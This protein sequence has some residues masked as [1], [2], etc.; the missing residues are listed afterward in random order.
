MD[1]I[2]SLKDTK[3]TNNVVR[4]CRVERAKKKQERTRLDATKPTKPVL[5]KKPNARCARTPRESH[6]LPDNFNKVASF[7]DEQ[8]EQTKRQETPPPGDEWVTNHLVEL[9]AAG[10]NSDDL[11]RESLP[12]GIVHMKVFNKPDLTI[13]IEL[14]LLTFSWKNPGGGIVMQTCRP[15]GVLNLS[16]NA[17]RN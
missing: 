4:R 17:L 13:K 2:A 6:S 7:F 3:N 12:R 8:S 15:E 5:W 9:Q 1:W 11:F 14:D 16:A 10:F